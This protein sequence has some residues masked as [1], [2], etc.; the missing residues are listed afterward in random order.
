MFTG[1]TDAEAEA[2]ILWLADAKSRL[3]RKDPFAGKDERKEEKGT[4]KNEM[5]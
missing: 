1:R 2:P 4:T 5:G 3:F